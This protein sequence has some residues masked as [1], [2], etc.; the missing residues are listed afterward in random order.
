MKKAL[1]TLI[2]T[3]LILLLTSPAFSDDITFGLGASARDDDATLYF[4]IKMKRF[5][6]EPMISYAKM[7]REY[8][9]ASQEIEAEMTAYSVGVGVL[10]YNEV[11]KNTDL[12]Y[13]VRFG[14]I[15]EETD[16]E[17]SA[18]GSVDRSASID[19]QGYFVA[20]TVGFEYNFTEHI[21]AGLYFSL[22]YSALDGEQ[23]EYD[24]VDFSES[25][26]EY[27]GFSTE[28]DI[29]LKFYF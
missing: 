8:S 26:V 1:G 29:F 25:D 27:S 24:G 3:S 23:N 18:T 12:I 10:M 9:S 5:I 16:E 7:D 22:E 15:K 14:Y 2:L 13:G 20:P 21:S 17:W 4:P 6:I 11:M 28:T 19:T